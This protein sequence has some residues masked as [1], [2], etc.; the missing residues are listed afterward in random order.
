MLS[1]TST[2][3]IDPPD[4][5]MPTA[6]LSTIPVEYSTVM[7]PVDALTVAPFAMEVLTTFTS[8]GAVSLQSGLWLS[9]QDVI[10]ENRSA[11]AR[12]YAVV[13]IISCSVLILRK[14]CQTLPE[15]HGFMSISE[16]LFYCQ[17]GQDDIIAL[18][19]QTVVVDELVDVVGSE[20]KFHVCL[21][22]RTV[23]V[24]LCGS[25]SIAQSSPR[26]NLIQG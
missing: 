24:F 1:F 26:P 9:S 8:T 18:N 3:S 17:F 20:D 22:C 12:I 15:N 7:L 6:G 2:D 23:I 5:V 21:R 16:L 14:D 13:F 11:P 25:G 19:Q 10:P 4:S